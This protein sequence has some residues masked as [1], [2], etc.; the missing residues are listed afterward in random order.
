MFTLTFKT[1]N[2]AFGD[3]EGNPLAREAEIASILARIASQVRDGVRSRGVSD[4]NG[5]RIGQWEIIPEPTTYSEARSWDWNLGYA[6]GFAGGK[7]AGEEFEL[8]A[9]RRLLAALEFV[10][11]RLALVI[12]CDADSGFPECETNNAALK[13]AQDAI[14]FAKR[15]A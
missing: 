5:N 6:A 10:E 12:E 4:S 9:N 3:G 15:H 7:A 2:A 14:A 11:D 8:E 13:Q 1:D